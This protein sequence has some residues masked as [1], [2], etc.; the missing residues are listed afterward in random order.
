MARRRRA[1]LHDGQAPVEVGMGGVDHADVPDAGLYLITGQIIGVTLHC[2]GLNE[3]AR[4]VAKRLYGRRRFSN[5][6]H[7]ILGRQFP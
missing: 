2:I 4:T 5:P 3:R 7:G 6:L 1:G